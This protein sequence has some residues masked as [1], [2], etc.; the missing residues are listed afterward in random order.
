M[1]INS[2]DRL[3]KVYNK[4]SSVLNTPLLKELKKRPRICEFIFIF[5]V[6]TV[7]A[8]IFDGSALPYPHEVLYG[9]WQVLTE[10]NVWTHISYTFTS[11]FIAF[12]ITMAIGI[13][14]G[15]SMATNEYGTKL[16]LPYVVI[17]LSVPAIAWAAIA[18][19]IYGIGIVVPILSAILV[20]YPIVALII[21][22]GVEDIDANRIQMSD[23]FD[24][25]RR[26]MVRRIILPEIAPTLF[27]SSRYGLAVGWKIV[28]IAEIFAGSRG[29]G[30]MII[31]TFDQFQWS[32]T[33]AWAVIFIGIVLFIEYAIF[34]PLEKRAYKYKEAE[35][36]TAMG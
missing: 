10:G 21:W 28:T 15:I 22:K 18:T 3:S 24:I 9:T 30:Y 14:M 32:R 4:Y 8:Y 5:S 13:V 26:R 31:L 7:L 35:M 23:S 19:L 6:W 12:F 1:A 17:G 2:S 29:I 27:A 36:Y 11:T 34:Q 33:W 25:S 16:F 20:M